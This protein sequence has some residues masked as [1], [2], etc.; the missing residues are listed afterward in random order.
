[1][2]QIQIILLAAD[3]HCALHALVTDA[4]G[5]LHLLEFKNL[6]LSH[7]LLLSRE[8]EKKKSERIS[9]IQ[10]LQ[11]MLTSTD[12]RLWRDKWSKLEGPHNYHVHHSVRLFIRTIFQVLQVTVF[13]ST[14]CSL[15]AIYSHIMTELFEA[16]S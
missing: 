14:Q 11:M 7:C 15:L 16:M 3:L 12:R 4:T 10:L 5:C 8:L 6:C 13:N 9:G 1:M 2:I